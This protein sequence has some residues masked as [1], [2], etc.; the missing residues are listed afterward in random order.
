MSGGTG[1]PSAEAL[2]QAHA[3]VNDSVHGAWAASIIERAERHGQE[4][5]A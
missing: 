2:A 3:I 5:A 1:R 4:R